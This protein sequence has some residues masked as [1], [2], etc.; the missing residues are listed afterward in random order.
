MKVKKLISEQQLFSQMIQ[1]SEQAFEQIFHHYNARIYPFMLKKTKSH[2]LSEELVQELFIKLW[3]GRSKLVG[4][5]N[6]DAYIFSMAAHALL[7]HWRKVSRD[8]DMRSRLWQ[9]LCHFNSL[10]EDAVA[11]KESQS[12]IQAAVELLPPQRKKIYLMSRAEGLSHE[13][14]ARM[15]SLSRST[16]N[17][18]LGQALKFIREYIDKQHGNKTSLSAMLL[19]IL[20]L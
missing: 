3:E 5:K 4:V 7:N 20:Q 2:H 17:N 10:T 13:E 6:P 18:Q 14:I 16:V 19:F 12:I 11:Y 8:A 1:G 15:L 9:D